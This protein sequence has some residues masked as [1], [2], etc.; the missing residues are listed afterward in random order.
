MTNIF[1]ITYDYTWNN[2]RHHIIVVFFQV[3]RKYDTRDL[4]TWIFRDKKTYE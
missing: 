1:L 3:G 4:L 2:R